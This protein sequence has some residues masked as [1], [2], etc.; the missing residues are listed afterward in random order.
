[1]IYF[2]T[3]K[4]HVLRSMG[5]QGNAKCDKPSIEN[6]PLTFMEQTKHAGVFV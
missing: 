2:V 1:M 5:N 6:N 3:Y 4:L